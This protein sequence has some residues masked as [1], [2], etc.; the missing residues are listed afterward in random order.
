MGGSTCFLGTGTGF[1]GVGSWGLAGGWQPALVTRLPSAS[2]PPVQP[3]TLMAGPSAAPR[4]GLR[5]A[6]VWWWLCT[7]T[8]SRPMRRECPGSWGGGQYSVSLV[9]LPAN[10]VGLV[11]CQ[12]IQILHQ[13]PKNLSVEGR[14]LAFSKKTKEILLWGN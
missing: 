3:R 14:E 7:A 10:S 2:S 6:L 4:D 11:L 5:P 13:L 9:L 8:R 12:E 1:E